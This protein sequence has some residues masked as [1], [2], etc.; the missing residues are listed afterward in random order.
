MKKFMLFSVFVATLLLAGCQTGIGRAASY[1]FKGV[2][3]AVP[4]SLDSIEQSYLADSQNILDDIAAGKAET[5]IGK[6]RKAAILQKRVET[7]KAVMEQIRYLREYVGASSGQAAEATRKAAFDRQ[8]ELM[9][10]ASE[11]LIQ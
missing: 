10:L 9:K 5:D 8:I 3:D 1:A 11:H 7:Q 2:P 6:A 4:A